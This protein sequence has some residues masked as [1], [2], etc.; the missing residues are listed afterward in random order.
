M[1]RYPTLGFL[2]S[3]GKWIATLALVAGLLSG[4]YAWFV[5]GG[6]LIAT[7][8]MLVG[9]FAYGVIRSFA[10]LAAL[11]TDMLLPS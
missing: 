6:I 9:I 10:E 2:I 4:L 5:A 11:V 8:L 3:H 7:L 1:E